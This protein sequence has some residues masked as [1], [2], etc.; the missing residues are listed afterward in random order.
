VR[1]VDFVDGRLEM[2]WT[3]LPFW[4]AAGP[5]LHDELEVMIRDIVVLNGL[6]V[7]DD[8]LDRIHDLVVRLIARRFRIGG[9]GEYLAAVRHVREV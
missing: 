5:A 2:R 7:T 8:S 4:L 6:P 1:F 3:W 9:L